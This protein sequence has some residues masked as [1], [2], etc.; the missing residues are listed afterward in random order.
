MNPIAGSLLA[1][2]LCLIAPFGA[3]GGD[4]KAVPETSAPLVTSDLS[5]EKAASWGVEVVRAVA[6]SEPE[7]TKRHAAHLSTIRGDIR[8]GGMVTSASCKQRFSVSQVLA[9]AGRAGER[10]IAY[11]FIESA[12]GFPLPRPRRPVAKGEKVVLVLGVGGSPVKVIPDADENRKEI[13]AVT[14]YV[15]ARPPAAQALLKAMSSFTLK[16]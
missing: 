15:K 8:G 12:Q 4:K 14:E 9:G 13:E 3:D 10:E 6:A 16:I 11:S 7:I 1:G 5:A 2:C